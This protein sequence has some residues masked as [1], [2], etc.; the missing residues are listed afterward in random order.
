MSQL[1]PPVST[2]DH[3]QGHPGASIELVE[4]GDYQCPHCGRAYAIIKAIQK[5][6][7]SDL[8]FVFRNFPLSQ[9]HP[10]ALSAALACEAASLQN[11]F[12]VMHDIVFEH[13][14]A[15]K[16]SDLFTYAK[17][18]GLDTD[19]FSADFQKQSLLD[20]IDSDIESGIRSGVNG[21]PSLFIQGKMYNGN[22]EDEK[23]FIKFLRSNF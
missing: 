17:Q 19:Q 21:T 7:A 2:E 11:R 6:L 12:W 18:I 22:W 23:I 15:L 1:K 3:L 13:Q 14:Q 10:D 5:Q 8:K 9:L 4:Y 20:K 16:K